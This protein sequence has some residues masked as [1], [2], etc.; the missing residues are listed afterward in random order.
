M[1]DIIVTNRLTHI[2][3]RK[4]ACIYIYIYIYIDTCCSNIYTHVYIS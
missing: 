3:E 2:N 1:Y 4:Y